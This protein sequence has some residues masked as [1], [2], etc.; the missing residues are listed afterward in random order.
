M[1]WL[2]TFN[3]VTR[4]VSPQGFF[5]GQLLALGPNQSTL[6]KN[7]LGI[8]GTQKTFSN[9]VYSSADLQLLAAAG[10]DVITNPVPGGSY[11][12]ARFGHNSSSNPLIHGDNY[13][14]M[15]NYIASTLNAGMGQ[16][17]GVP[18]AANAIGA[19]GTPSANA[20]GTLNAYFAN[21]QAQNLIGTPGGP[22]AY[23]NQIDV[24]NNPALQVG[25][26]YLSSY[27]KVQ[28]QSIIE[29]LLVTIQGG[30]TVQIQRLS[31]VA[32]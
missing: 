17:V 18:Q 1:Y 20:L 11:F 26:G 28:Y 21:L 29:E 14:R 8:V 15:T 2:D 23:S 12:G 10:I 32:V 25:L 19:A 7:F 31:T 22:V 9:Q 5:L 4:L 3:Q 6:N 27:T 30:Q 16:F 13:T 24:N